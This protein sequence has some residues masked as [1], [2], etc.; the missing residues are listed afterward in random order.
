MVEVVESVAGGV[1]TGGVVELFADVPE[2][3]PRWSRV[4]WVRLKNPRHPVLEQTHL[5]QNL[6]V[7]SL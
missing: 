4:Q 5:E 7:Q 3:P 6:Y 2:T 1:V